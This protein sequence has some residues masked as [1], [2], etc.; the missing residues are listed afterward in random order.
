MSTTTVRRQH[1]NGHEVVREFNNFIDVR[2]F[3]DTPGGYPWLVMAAN[4]HLSARDIHLFLG[5]GNNRR[6]ESWLKRRRW[7]FRKP[8][9]PQAQRSTPDRDGQQARATKIMRENP[10]LSVRQL[11]VLVNKKGIKRS[12][13]WVRKHRCD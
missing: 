10:R 6:P 5:Q 3:V 9:D 13:E 12:R 4:P 2:E 11:T 7:L 8:G 1:W